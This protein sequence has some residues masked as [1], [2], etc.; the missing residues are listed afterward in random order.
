[1]K[2]LVKYLAVFSAV[3]L[4]IFSIAL[5]IA[6]NLYNS[7]IQSVIRKINSKQHYAVLNY[8]PLSSS[9]LD[10]E[11]LLSVEVPASKY[12]KIK[13]VFKVNVDFSF[14]S[15]KATFSK[16]RT[17]FFVSANNLNSPGLRPW[18][19][20]QIVTIE[21]TL[22]DTLKVTKKDTPMVT[23]LMTAKCVTR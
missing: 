18:G 6:S 21:V 3:I 15:V 5:V 9:I 13:A 2:R 7:K 22:F 12:G 17:D 1:M 20:L 16:S 8:S 19:V 10:K 14:S 23:H 4:I 11:G